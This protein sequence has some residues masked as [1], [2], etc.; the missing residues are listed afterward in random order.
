MTPVASAQ[1]ASEWCRKCELI[2][3]IQEH[4]L[5]A[6]VPVRQNLHL[7]VHLNRDVCLFAD[8][9]GHAVSDVGFGRSPAEMVGSNTV[10]SWKFI[11]CECCV[12]QGRGL[13]DVLITRS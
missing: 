11:C 8:P 2:S 6:S 12:L 5:T 10:E 3:I 1:N 4:Q 13:C 7:K 9:G